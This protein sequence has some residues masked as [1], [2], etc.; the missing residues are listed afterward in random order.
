VNEPYDRQFRRSTFCQGGTC[1]E[2][3]PLP[4]GQ[5]AVRD[6]KDL[7]V[8]RHVYTQDEWVAFIQGVKAGEFDFDPS[9]SPSA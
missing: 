8:P 2:V 4:D 1:V 6:S 7:S 5:I 3:A 9:H